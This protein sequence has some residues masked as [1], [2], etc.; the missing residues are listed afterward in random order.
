MIMASFLSLS[1]YLFFT[2]RGESLKINHDYVV[3]DGRK[4]LW[5]EVISYKE[6]EDAALFLYRKKDMRYPKN[7]AIKFSEYGEKKKLIRSLLKDI[8]SSVN[9][10]K[11]KL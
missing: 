2:K 6:N 11:E 5:N 7:V 8:L 4:I 1:K 3:I 9:V 10:K